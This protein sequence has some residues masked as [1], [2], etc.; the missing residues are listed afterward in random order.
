MNKEIS[1]PF[2]YRKLIKIIFLILILFLMIGGSIYA[3]SSFANSSINNAIKEIEKHDEI[4]IFNVVDVSFESDIDFLEVVDT[5]LIYTDEET[6]VV[7]NSY[8]KFYK[9]DNEE[10]TLRKI[11]P[12]EILEDLP[13]YDALDNY[14]PYELILGKKDTQ[15]ISKMYA[16]KYGKTFKLEKLKKDDI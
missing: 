4:E 6:F 12:E 1:E 15:E 5:V 10:T 9:S 3:L 16:E 13:E 8:I 2:K 7:D 11:F 14:Y